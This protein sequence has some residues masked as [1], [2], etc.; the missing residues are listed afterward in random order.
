[1]HARHPTNQAFKTERLMPGAEL[2][3][4]A[5][6]GDSNEDELLI[7]LPREADSPQFCEPVSCIP[8]PSS[9]TLSMLQ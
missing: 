7:S 9:P 5:T 4:E 8:R 6:L 2:A 1:M 3:D